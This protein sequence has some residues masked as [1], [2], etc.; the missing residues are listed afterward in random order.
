VA[1][2]QYVVRSV[3]LWQSRWRSTRQ[4]CGVWVWSTLDDSCAITTG[5]S[6]TSRSQHQLLCLS[7]PSLAQL[8]K[9]IKLTA[10]CHLSLHSQ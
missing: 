6:S 9:E 1:E 4:W 8:H 3:C 10:T 5:N 2:M 7:A